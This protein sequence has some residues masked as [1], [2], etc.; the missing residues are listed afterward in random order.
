MLSVL[1]LAAV[2]TVYLLFLML[3]SSS[4]IDA[5][6]QSS[7]LATPFPP[8][9]LEIYNLF[10]SC[11]LLAVRSCIFSSAFLS[12]SPFVYVLPSSISRMV[13]IILKGELPM[14]LFL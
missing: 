4:R 10:M 6:T 1:L 12:S 5:S 11:H 8:P 9:F 7:V 3:S 14:C 2:M 13:T